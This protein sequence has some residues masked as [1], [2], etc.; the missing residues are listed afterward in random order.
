MK[1]NLIDKFII[2]IIPYL[3]GSGK[4]LFKPGRPSQNIK[5]VGSKTFSSGLVQLEYINL[6]S[7]IQ[8]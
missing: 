5:F 6:A 7:D 4:Q 8:S 3:L 1:E 2:S